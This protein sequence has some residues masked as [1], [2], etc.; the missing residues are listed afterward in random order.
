MRERSAAFISIDAMSKLDDAEEE[1]N[2]LKNIREAQTLYANVVIAST[3]VRD[4][5]TDLRVKTVAAV[6]YVTKRIWWSES[7]LW[8]ETRCEFVLVLCWF[9]VGFVLCCICVSVAIPATVLALCWWYLLHWLSKLWSGM[10]GD[11]NQTQRRI[12]WIRGKERAE[13]VLAETITIN[14]GRNGSVNSDPNPMCGRAGAAGD[15]TTTSRQDCGEN[16]GRRWRRERVSGPLVLRRQVEERRSP[17]FRRQRSKSFGPRLSS[18]ESRREERQDKKDRA[19]RQEEKVVLRK[20]GWSMDCEDGVE[21]KKKMDGQ[22]K[23]LQKHLR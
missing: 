5:S 23:R 20:T 22:R 15:A 17:K 9:C 21:S 1:G 13:D 14:G 16:T 7:E 3:T 6:A 2:N 12:S 18:L 11:L 19:T 8:P 10:G 4:S